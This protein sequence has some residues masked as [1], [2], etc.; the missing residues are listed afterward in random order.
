MSVGENIRFY[1]KKAGLTQKQLADI[2]NISV[3]CIKQYETNKRHPKIE[4]LR[5]I[6]KALNVTE[7]DLCTELPKTIGQL[8]KEARKEKGLTQDELAEISNVNRN[9]IHKYEQGQRMP[10]INFIKSLASALDKPISYFYSGYDEQPQEPQE[11]QEEPSI[12]FKRMSA[13]EIK[14]LVVEAT[15]ELINRI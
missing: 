3:N 7:Q 10:R 14:Q 8:I 13:E 2:C 5:N 12:N 6:S 9:T 15:N 4:Y 11:H 1:R